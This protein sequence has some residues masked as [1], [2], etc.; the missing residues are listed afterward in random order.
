M[1]RIAAHPR[2]TRII[3]E[4]ERRGAARQGATLAALLSE[5]ELRRRDAPPLGSETESDVIAALE[6]FERAERDRLDGNQLESRGIDPG[7]FFAVKRQ[8]DHLLRGLDQSAKLDG[9]RDTVLSLALLSGFPDRVARRRAGGARGVQGTIRREEL[10]FATGGGGELSGSSVVKHSEWLVAVDAEEQISGGQKRALVRAASAISLDWLLELFTDRIADGQEVVWNAK[11]ERVECFRRMRYEE[12]II[13]ESVDGAPDMD[14]VAEVLFVAAQA[15]GFAFFVEP[16]ALDRLQARVAF[17]QKHCPELGFAALD[18]SALRDVLRRA[19][20]GQR[21][22]S[23]LREASPLHLAVAGFSDSQRRQLAH[24][25][26]E[27]LQLPGGRQAPID[28]PAGQPPH[29]SSR[30]QD[31]FGM[32]DGPKLA[33]G[34]V[35]LVIHLLAPNGRD[36]QVTTD[37]KGFWQRHYPGI[38]KELRRRYPRHSWPDD[39]LTASPPPVNARRR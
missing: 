14:K 3:L 15:K 23:G 36:V 38:A 10:V 7:A 13:D 1:A 37:L 2:L 22:F 30:L 28:Y 4:A 20:S 29:I 31:F 26:P 21:S 17:L 25:A 34:R 5:R 32:Q 27:R 8:R 35:P 33:G 18:D 16:E 6:L 11:A 9:D 39:P 24:E 12:F 19:C